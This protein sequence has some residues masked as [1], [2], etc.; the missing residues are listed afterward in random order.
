MVSLVCLIIVLT[1]A[2]DYRFR[3]HV[4]IDICNLIVRSK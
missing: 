1:L 3:F 2:H 4:A